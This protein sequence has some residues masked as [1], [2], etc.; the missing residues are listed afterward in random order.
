MNYHIF[1]LSLAFAV[2]VAASVPEKTTESW[3]LVEL[4]HLRDSLTSMGQVPYGITASDDLVDVNSDRYSLKTGGLVE[5]IGFP[6]GLGS[7]NYG[8]DSD[9][10]PNRNLLALS[11]QDNPNQTWAYPFPPTDNFLNYGDMTVRFAPA[12]D[13]LVVT[14]N[15]TYTLWSVRS[16]RLERRVRFVDA[17]AQPHAFGQ[18]TALS[19]DGS[20]VVYAGV[21]M[22]LTASTLTGQV[23]NRVAMRP[24]STKYL[25]QIIFV[26][27]FGRYAL[28]EAPVGAAVSSKARK[29]T[30]RDTR[31]GRAKWGFTLPPNTSNSSLGDWQTAFSS[32][33]T[34]IAV[35]VSARNLWRIRSLQTGKT[36]RTLPRL[37]GAQIAA[38]SPDNGTLYSVANGVLYRQRAR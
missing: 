35:P 11:L 6:A 36:I 38:F 5:Q 23:L 27:P 8:I 24:L 17:E 9:S 7:W 34:Q 33:E 29:L 32:D 15:G 22:I 30:V 10:D 4:V 14:L 3:R 2:P 31:T 12:I 13:R 21:K 25:D 16:R 37:R 28:Y 26:S 19:R 1:L 18:T 20:T